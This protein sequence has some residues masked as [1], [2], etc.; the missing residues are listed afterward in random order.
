ML[1][2]KRNIYNIKK[3]EKLRKEISILCNAFQSFMIL[4]LY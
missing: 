3:K 2:K 4:I 1:K